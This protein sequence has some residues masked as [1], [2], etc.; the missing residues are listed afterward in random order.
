MSDFN[1]IK[2]DTQPEQT[3]QPTQQPEPQ[4]SKPRRPHSKSKAAQIR[5][6][7]ERGCDVKEIAKKV[8]VPVTYVYVIRS[9]MKGEGKSKSETK[10]EAADKYTKRGLAAISTRYPK[11][12]PGGIQEIKEQSAEKVSLW[13]R[14][15]RWFA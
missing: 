2:A 9:K 13:G 8:G 4:K 12:V 6:L 1:E 5:K 7:V 11:P 3:Q 10:G 14:I 15:K